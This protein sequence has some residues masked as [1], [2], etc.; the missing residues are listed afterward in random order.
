MNC[1]RER[2]YRRAV[3]TPLMLVAGD[4]AQNDM[5]GPG[6]TSWLSQFRAAG[7]E[8]RAVV[9]GLGQYEEIRALYCEH[10][11]KAAEHEG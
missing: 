8:T 11:R 3:L 4:H 7:I 1:V 10:A 5:T 2:G 6:S 9:R